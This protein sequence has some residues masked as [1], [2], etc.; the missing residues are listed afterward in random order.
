MIHTFDQGDLTDA[1]GN[2]VKLLLNGVDVV[3]G[4]VINVG[5]TLSC[6]TIGNYNFYSYGVRMKAYDMNQGNYIYLDFDGDSNTI[7]REFT[8]FDGSLS[9]GFYFYT[10]IFTPRTIHTFDQGD[11][12]DAS[13]NGTT[14]KLNDVDAVVGDEI[15]VG[16]VLSCSVVGE[17][18]FTSYGLRMKAYN[19]N[20]GDYAYLDFDGDDLIISRTFTDSD[21]TLSYQLIFY[22]EIFIPRVIYTFTQ[23]DIDLMSINECSILKGVDVLVAGSV[24]NDGDTLTGVIDNGADR[25]FIDASSTDGGMWFKSYDPNQGDYF[26]AIFQNSEG[27]KSVE[28]TFTTETPVLSVGTFN[29]LTDVLAPKVVASN[30]VYSINDDILKAV[31][32]ARF[33]ADVDGAVIDYGAYILSV[34]QLPFN[35]DVDNVGGK[36]NIVLGEIS[37]TV[38]ADELTTDKL[39]F[40]LGEIVVTSVEN[41]L[42][43]YV[44]TVAKLHLPFAPSIDVDLEY[45]IDCIIKIKYTLDCYTGEV[46]INVVSDDAGVETVVSST[47]VDIGVNIP[48][49]STQQIGTIENNNIVVGG[50]NDVRTAFIELVKDEP[51]LIN[52]LFSVPV[53]DE[54]LLTGKTGFIRVNE[55]DVGNVGLK[56]E[57]DALIGVLNSGII[58]KW[59]KK[60][61]LLA[62]DKGEFKDNYFK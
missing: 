61:P 13:N 59:H 19:P 25:V 37:T 56:D 33:I 2:N 55:I 18:R 38:I 1:S 58:I 7:S 28:Y 41:N 54:G 5:D 20:Q 30:N 50:D 4:D 53:T 46:T 49:T 60:T 40:D 47:Q 12:T 3:V 39:D 35:L 29:V 52:G 27:N 45:V 57:K 15:K 24:I 62:T 16:D 48:Y 44:N 14:L 17:Y 43:D 6:E 23:S 9:Y 42:L 21:L 22:T 34:L 8:S 32:D 26:W 51:L 11:L 31:N 10:E 36:S